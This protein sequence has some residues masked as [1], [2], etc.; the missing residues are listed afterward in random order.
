[1][2]SAVQVRFQ[3]PDAQALTALKEVDEL[4]RSRWGRGLPKGFLELHERFG[5]LRVEIE[6]VEAHGFFAPRELRQ[7]LELNDPVSDDGTQWRPYLR[8]VGS[9]DMADWAAFIYRCASPGCTGCIGPTEDDFWNGE[10]EDGTLTYKAHAAAD[11]AQ[12]LSDWVETGMSLDGR[13]GAYDG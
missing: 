3:Q 10:W 1:M 2:S 13:T 12:W 11:F 8:F 6:G 9:A 7:V 4:L 5:T